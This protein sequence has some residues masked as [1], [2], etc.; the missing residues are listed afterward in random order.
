MIW[1]KIFYLSGSNSQ[2]QSYGFI[3]F[4]LIFLT[5]SISAEIVINE[6]LY[7]P[8]SDDSDEEYIELMNTSSSAV[9]LTRWSFSRGI[10]FYFPPATSIPPGGFLVVAR[11]RNR[12]LETYGSL[13]AQVL[14]DFDGSLS[15]GGEQIILSDSAGRI[16]DEVNYSDKSP[17]NPDADGSGRSLECIDP[18]A[19]NDDFRNWLPSAIEIGSATGTPGRLNSVTQEAVPPFIYQVAHK[20]HVP[21]SGESVQVTVTV[22]NLEPVS[23]SL[24]YDAGNGY[25]SVPM[26]EEGVRGAWTLGYGRYKATIPGQSDG[27]LVRYYIKA[28]GETGAIRL[29]P[30]E[31]PVFGRGWRVPDSSDPSSLAHDELLLDPIELQLFYNFPY[32]YSR[33]AFG[34]YIADGELYDNVK[35]RMRGG[36]SRDFPKKNWRV[37]FPKSH[38]FRGVDRRINFN[39]DYHDP[40][41]MRNILSM[42]LLKRLGFPVEGT[43]Y[44]RLY[45]NGEY[46][47]VLY[48]IEH[49]NEEWLLRNGRDPNADLY[50]SAHDHT[51]P[52]FR[53]D[54]SLYYD[55]K[56]GE[57]TDDYTSIRVFI[58]GL[59]AQSIGE[60]G[61]YLEATFDID[62]LLNYMVARTL[63]SNAD[64]RYK[65]HFLYLHSPFD[66]GLWEIIPHDLD[67]TW[68]HIWTEDRGLLNE[69][70]RTDMPSF[71][72]PNRLMA[73]V[74]DDPDLR[75]AYYERLK[76]ALQD[77]FRED[78]WWPR[79]D[80]LYDMIRED[81]FA[82]THKW[83]S[84]EAFDAQRLQLREYVTLRRQ[85]LLEFEIP[86]EQPSPT[87]TPTV[88]PTPTAVPTPMSVDLAGVSAEPVGGFS[89]VS[90]FGFG[91]VPTD[92]SYPGATDGSGL[93]LSLNRH[94][95][96]FLIPA[97]PIQIDDNLVQLSVASRST[98][99]SVQLALVAFAYPVD[100]SFGYVSSTGR[101]VSVDRWG[102]LRVVYDSP[103]RTILPAIQVVLPQEADEESCTVYLDNLQL[104]SFSH[105]NAISIETVG[106]GTFD[107]VDPTLTGMNP[108]LF[109]PIGKAPGLVSVTEGSSG[110]G[111]RLQLESNQLAS[112]IALFSVAP[113]MPSTV[114]GSV[115]VKKECSDANG[116]LAFVLTDGEK[117]VGYFLQT[118]HLPLAEFKQIHFGGNFEISGKEIPPIAVVQLGGPDVSCSLVIDDLQLSRSD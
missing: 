11:D 48:R 107:S 117:S 72:L 53:G 6:I 19:S 7:H 76:A 86:A 64:D 108:N 106:D 27:T 112:H 13:S 65:N 102:E 105:Q 104:V 29:F 41:H 59:N 49:I 50:K 46:F 70:F 4:L 20:P 67:L 114:Y 95:G 79:I 92:N 28:V 38:L 47:G 98:S 77:V 8:A 42:E 60:S 63:L 43:Q 101:E 78:I 116:T 87:P 66:S 89:E 1:K 31:A 14:G 32:D 83:E 12:F 26:R 93:I 75:T 80:E 15:N 58:E 71:F 113:T 9:D 24:F 84:N 100:G 51:L 16:H 23:V 103:T 74:R 39:S 21:R 10:S 91:A 55:K 68:G 45:F 22:E 44:T 99:S 5:Q 17:W 73:V 35:I 52:E 2:I 82:D 18:T 25:A 111:I 54:Y 81:V 90:E 37:N 115:K 69:T 61:P 56:T 109:I 57:D 88:T 36:A 34:S 110:Q 62:S 85:Y 3:L 97:G 33:Q 40:S 30:P 94:E 118:N 96:V